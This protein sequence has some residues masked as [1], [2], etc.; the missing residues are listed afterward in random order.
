[1]QTLL[2]ML[3]LVGMMA[4]AALGG[5]AVRGR[6]PEHHTAD[7]SLDAVLRS[8]GLVVTL[9]AVVLGFLVGSA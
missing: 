2:L 9:S 6:L 5:M 4:A 8:V 7:G 3:L 1:M